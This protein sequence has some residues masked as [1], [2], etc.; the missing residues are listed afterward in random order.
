[1]SYGSDKKFIFLEIHVKM[2]NIFFV[3]ENDMEK[4]LKI[5]ELGISI[6]L[7]NGVPGKIFFIKAHK[8]TL[9]KVAQDL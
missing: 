8:E 2:C 6:V 5:L 9:Q 4:L 7:F 1:M 3:D